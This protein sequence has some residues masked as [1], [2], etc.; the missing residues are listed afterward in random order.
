MKNF[1]DWTYRLGPKFRQ[2]EG[3]GPLSKSSPIFL[4]MKMTFSLNKFWYGVRQYQDEFVKRI[5]DNTV[6]DS[7]TVRSS[8]FSRKD[9]TI[10][11]LTHFLAKNHSKLPVEDKN[12]I[13]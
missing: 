8:N 4:T 2:R 10:R 1:S 3:A 6:K 11:I 13:Q 12:L 9:G 7:V 5:H